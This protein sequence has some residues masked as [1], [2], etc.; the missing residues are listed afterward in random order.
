[1]A[2]DVVCNMEV[3]ERVGRFQSVFQGK[4]YYFC[5]DGCLHDFDE[6]P[7]RYVGKDQ[8][9][10]FEEPEFTPPGSRGDKAPL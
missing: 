9:L 8:P 1:M 4:R 7:L 5:S 3:D 6:D 10:E 2:I